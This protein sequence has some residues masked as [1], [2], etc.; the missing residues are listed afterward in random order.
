MLYCL[1]YICVVF[2]LCNQN[3]V[4][5]FFSFPVCCVFAVLL[6]IVCIVVDQLFVFAIQI[7]VRGSRLDDRSAA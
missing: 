7:M 3:I 2:N 4:C 1:Q 6:F 5:L